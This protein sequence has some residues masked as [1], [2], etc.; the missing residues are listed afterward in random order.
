MGLGF[1]GF[2]LG[3]LGFELRVLGFELWVHAMWLG[4]RTSAVFSAR[5]PAYATD[6]QVCLKMFE[7]IGRVPS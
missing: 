2:R 5:R 6:N 4:F 1:A 7:V 3:V